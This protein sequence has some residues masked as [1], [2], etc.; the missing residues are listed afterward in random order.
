MRGSHSAAP[1]EM[2][3]KHSLRKYLE[4]RE[5]R[6]GVEPAKGTGVAGD[7]SS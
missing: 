4:R 5:H 3:R 6:K 7:S 1:M 2:S